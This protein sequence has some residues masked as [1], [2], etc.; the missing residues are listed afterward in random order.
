M[1]HPENHSEN[2][3]PRA[4]VA[5]SGRD[6]LLAAVPA[7]LGFHPAESLTVVCLTGPNRRV[8]PVIRADLQVRT[9]PTGAA[10]ITVP[11]L[12]ALADI[13]ARHADEVALIL[14]TDHPHPVG[15]AAIAARLRQ[16]R[17]VLDTITVP[18]TAQPL[19]D[20]L[21]A[22]NAGYGRAVLADRAE[23]T[24]SVQH[25]PTPSPPPLTLRCWPRWQRWLG[26]TR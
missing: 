15:A 6:G 14:Y 21:I 10:H 7:I 24:R 17:P 23:L 11:A 22:A 25:R 13:V 4:E 19:P 3:A 16:V 2:P 8:G 20:A 26:G 18:N 5:L 9:D 12:S 1:R